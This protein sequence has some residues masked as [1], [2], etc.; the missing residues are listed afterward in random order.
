MGYIVV[1][2]VNYTGWRTNTSTFSSTRSSCAA[3][4]S[5]LEE[6]YRCQDEMMQNLMHSQ[7]H[8]LVI[9]HVIVSYMLNL[10]NLI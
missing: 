1:D 3:T 6:R 8:I 9:L 7:Q 5:A 10:S 4:D 2:R